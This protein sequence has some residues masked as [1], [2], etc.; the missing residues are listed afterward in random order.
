M[1]LEDRL[2]GAVPASPALGT[3]IARWPHLQ[4]VTVACMWPVD[5]GGFEGNS[6]ADLYPERE[7]RPEGS[8]GSYELDGRIFQSFDTREHVTVDWL[9]SGAAD[10]IRLAVYRPL[11]DGGYIK[12]TWTFQR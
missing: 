3:E 8:W 9:E 10:Q 7:S 5:V 4:Q 12:A 1:R 11:D 6:F 2:V